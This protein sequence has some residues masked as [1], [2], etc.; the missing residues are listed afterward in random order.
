MEVLD[1]LSGCITM[2]TRSLTAPAALQAQTVISAI[3]TCYGEAN[4]Q[5]LLDTVLNGSGFYQYS[6]TGDSGTFTSVAVNS[7]IPQSFAA[8]QVFLY[9]RDLQTGCLDTV[10]QFI[11]QPD[12]LKLTASVLIG[13]QCFSPTGQ[14]KLTAFSGGTGV[15]SLQMKPPGSSIFF[16]VTLPADS[17][18]VGLSGGDYTFLVI[19][20]NNCSRLL[21]LNVPNDGPKA[22]QIQLIKPCIADSNGVI[23][24]TGVSGGTGPYVYTLANDQ[25]QVL[26]VQGD[27]TFTQL[28]AGT[29]SI[30]MQ[31]NSTPSCQ[32]IYTRTLEAPAPVRF[33]LVGTQSSTCENF[34]G[35]AKF[36]PLGGQPGYRYSFDTLAGVFTNF[37]PVTTDTLY[38]RGLS[39][40][41]TGNF[42]TLRFLDNGPA[43]GCPS[44]TTFNIPGN[45]PLRFKYTTRNVKCFGETSGAVLIDSLNGTG[46]V[47]LRVVREQTGELVKEDSIPGTFFLNNKFVLGGLPSGRFN[48]LMVQYGA[49]SASRVSSF[50]LTEPTQIQIQAR[51][52]KPS[53]LTFGMG[54]V[55]LDTVRGSVGPYLVSFNENVLFNYK[56][57][58]L[59]TGLEPGMYTLTVQDSIGCAVSKDIEVL[60][61]SSLFIPTLFTPNGDG[62]NDLF[63]IRNLPAGSGLVVKSRWGDEVFAAG[64]YKNDW[65]AKDVDNGT[66]FWV[67]NIPGQSSQSGWLEIQR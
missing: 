30:T 5:I 58:T 17:V 21:L 28:K 45:S 42:Y 63:E 20:Q 29:Y 8:G 55:L 9:I 64:S 23:K 25:G 33:H 34:D 3:P 59:F 46:P 39:T 6:L 48:L 26:K 53:A 15:V 31:D 14:V 43:N 56:P 13:S 1:T 7:P 57:D 49:C 40:R 47:K 52:Y 51:A 65:D 18:L 16:P 38:V 66:Y 2:V 62:F 11:L 35:V 27:S 54:S 44:D 22:T 32:T 12:S 41:T 67:L 61:D 4:A 50:E 10:G 60:K 36:L 37:K 24:L 19:D